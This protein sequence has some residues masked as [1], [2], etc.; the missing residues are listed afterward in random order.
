MTIQSTKTK[1][2]QDTTDPAEDDSVKI[3]KEQLL[4]MQNT[5]LLQRRLYFGEDIG[6]GTGQFVG[7][8]VSGVCD[9]ITGLSQLFGFLGGLGK[10]AQK[11]VLTSRAIFL[12]ARIRSGRDTVRTL[13]RKLDRA[14]ERH[15][16]GSDAF[17]SAEDLMD[18]AEQGKVDLSGLT[19]T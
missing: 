9:P 1:A 7:N 2:R 3:T 19:G 15:E 12:D 13:E 16:Q 10:G 5:L 17:M 8:F 11:G 4:Q 6:R 18:L 14:R